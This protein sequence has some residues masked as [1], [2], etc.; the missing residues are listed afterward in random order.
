MRHMWDLVR[1]QNPVMLSPTTSVKAACLHMRQRQA[2]AALI[3]DDTGHLLGI[4]T[5]RDAITRVLAEDRSSA[6]KLKD[7]M[8]PQPDA[9]SP[10]KPAI[11]ALRL[12]Q[13]G[14]F[15][16]LPIVDNG[17][18]VGVV[19]RGDFRGVELDRLDEETALRERIW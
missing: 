17:L 4:F 14:G 5:G 1:Q 19:S 15:R 9:I 2:G 7:V 6:T 8:T 10:D 12:M 11:D 16:H 13:D 18:V 3:V